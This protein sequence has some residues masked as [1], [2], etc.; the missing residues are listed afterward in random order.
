MILRVLLA[1]ALSVAVAA[2]V[3]PAGW[4]R[5]NFAVVGYLP[6]YRLGGFDYRAAFQTGLTHLLFFS[7][8]IDEHGQPA[9]LDRLPT[10]AAAAEARRAADEVGGKL[11]LSLGGNS[12]SQNFG[13]MATTPRVRQR[14]LAALGALLAEY[15]FDGV[16][17]NW[18][19]PAN[20]AE[21]RA[22]GELMRESKE[23]L[24][25]GRANNVVTFTMY[26]DP[27]HYDV[28]QRYQLLRD[29]DYVHCMAYDQPHQHATYA[30]YRSGVRLARD[31]GLDLAKFTM[32]LP[33]Y[34]RDTRNGEPKTYQELQHLLHNGVDDQVHHLYF[35]SKETI[36]KKT[37]NA[38]HERLGGVMI[39]EL[40]QDVQ[41]LSD[42]R[43]LM[44]SLHKE[45]PWYREG[46]FAGA[47]AAV[48]DVAPEGG[49]NG[50]TPAGASEGEL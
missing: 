23:Q 6:E 31:K 26:L 41:P 49:A 44:A 46:V 35:N 34:A 43:S 29:A 7:I 13:M 32:G 11:L 39:W 42:T 8:E 48:G 22:W 18:E 27:N 10:K 3:P 17:Y 16:D 30:F 4:Q 47:A 1:A 40:G 12:R 36:A 14:F 20:H 37:R 24:L 5:H 28:I 33:F 19:Y 50:D 15:Q 45:L 21:W 9:A 25:G 2:A 38:V